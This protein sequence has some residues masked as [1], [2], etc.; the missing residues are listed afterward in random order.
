MTEGKYPAVRVS[1]YPYFHIWTEVVRLYRYLYSGKI[2]SKRKLPLTGVAL[3]FTLRAS[4]LRGRRFVFNWGY[5]ARQVLGPSLRGKILKVLILVHRDP[6]VRAKQPLCLFARNR[7]A[8][9][10]SVLFPFGSGATMLRRSSLWCEVRLL[11][12]LTSEQTK[13]LAAGLGV[14]GGRRM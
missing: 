9:E 3:G 2:A 7:A 6:Y 10:F 14:F 1:F 12:S 8:G 11:G 4:L 5:K 13:A